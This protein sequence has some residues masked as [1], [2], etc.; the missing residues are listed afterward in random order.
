[1]TCIPFKIL[2]FKDTNR[3]TFPYMNWQPVSD[4]SRG[5][6]K[7]ININ[8]EV[9]TRCQIQ[10]SF[11]WM[12]CDPPT[13]IINKRIHFCHVFG[14]RPLK[15]VMQ[16]RNMGLFLTWSLLKTKG[17]YFEIT[18]FLYQL[19][20]LL[21]YFHLKLA[22]I[23]HHTNCLCFGYLWIFNNVGRGGGSGGR[24]FKELKNS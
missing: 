12:S 14:A 13:N 2:C 3:L 24:S 18:K 21:R 20:H 11:V 6:L 23:L 19:D 4:F 9:W 10:L 7:T 22:N 5:K 17:V 8:L 15:P 1:M 16:N